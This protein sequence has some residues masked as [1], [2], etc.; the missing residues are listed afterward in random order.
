MAG[1]VRLNLEL[2]EEVVLRLDELARL[3]GSTN[4]TEVI[5][6]ALSMYDVLLTKSVRGA[7][8]LIRESDG[9]ERSVLLI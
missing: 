3:S 2:A 5:R 9:T 7:E 8:L 1:K 4:R 6:R